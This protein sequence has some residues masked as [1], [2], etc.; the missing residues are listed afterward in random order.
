MAPHVAFENVVRF[1][2]GTAIAT[3]LGLAACSAGATDIIFETSGTGASSETGGTGGKKAGTA[4]AS[5]SGGT[6][7]GVTFQDDAGTLGSSCMSAADCTNGPVCTIAS[8]VVSGNQETQTGTCQYAPN[9]GCG[10]FTQMCPV[11]CAMGT[12]SYPAAV[13]LLPTNT[14]PNCSGGFELNN[15]DMASFT[16][17]A[18]SP[19]GSSAAPLDIEIATYLVP[20][21]IRITGIDAN[22]QEYT[23][24]DTCQMQTATYADP[25]N[26]CERP[27]DDSIRQYQVNIQAGTKSLKFD[28]SG[29]CTPWYVRV[30]GLCEFS[31]TPP[32]TTPSCAF[33]TIP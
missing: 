8:C 31:F 12:S 3:L 29:G 30:L 28:V 4:T 20:D 25:T 5:G 24:V 1:G 16:A 7:G 21:H 23:I 15:S 14:P 9:P 18:T 27:P 2:S 10:L 22:N 33:R 17:T 6:G 32:T 13:P 26:G 19:N 11:G